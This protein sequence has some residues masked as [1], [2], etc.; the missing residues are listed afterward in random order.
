MAKLDERA[1]TLGID[2]SV[3]LAGIR[4]SNPILPAS[5]TFMPEESGQ[6][7]DIS[8]LGAAVT[9]GVAPVPW[10]GNETPRIAE[11]YGGILNSV[12][13]QNPGVDAYIE[14]DMKYLADMGMKIITN[15][16]GHSVEDYVQ[17]VEKLA[18]RD[19]ISM[20]EVNISC[21]NVSAGGMSFGTD[22]EMAAEVVR[23]VR[24]LTRKPL[25]F[26]LTPNVTDI[27]EIAKAVEAEG[28]DGVT[29]IN[30]LLGMHIDVKRR[31]A[32]MA[33]KVGGMSG[34]AVKPVALRMVW[35]VAN[36]VKIPVI[37]VGGISTGT[38]V[39]EFLAAGATAV[40]V[41]TAALADP[42]AI[43]RIKSELIDYM[44]ENKFEKI[45]EMK[46]AF[47]I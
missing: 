18:D 28:A 38:D 27:T 7:Y 36:A 13:L 9:K 35:Q 23:A 15:V 2:L 20:F 5:G 24:R 16:A 26:K 11:V 40:E 22:P 3:N 44:N 42:L 19:E 14:N 39:V 17:V 31:R 45:S 10:A 46:H 21:P 29:L 6:F 43:P 41:G 1:K 30:T 47:E 4:L 12:G 33:R 8:E 25:F 37:G 32:T 34:P